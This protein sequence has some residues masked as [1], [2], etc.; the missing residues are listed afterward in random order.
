MEVNQT[1]QTMPAVRRYDYDGRT[2]IAADFG[3]AADPIVDIVDETAIVVL[4]DGNQREID[5]P[6][7][8]VEAF[9]RNGIVSFEVR[10]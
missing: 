8:S 5:L 9:N 10:E 1:S 2:V 3:P 7:G 6:S 4:S